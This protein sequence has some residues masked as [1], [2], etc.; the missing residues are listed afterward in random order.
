MNSYA[1]AERKLA[2]R[3]KI[4]AIVAAMSQDEMVVESDTKISTEQAID[5]RGYDRIVTKRFFYSV[6][7]G[8]KIEFRR[9]IFEHNEGLEGEIHEERLIHGCF[10]RRA[11]IP[12]KKFMNVAAESFANHWKPS[13]L[14]EKV[15]TEYFDG[16]Y[17]ETFRKGERIL[18]RRVV[19]Y[20]E[21]YESDT[22]DEVIEYHYDEEGNLIVS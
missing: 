10:K 4:V 13:H 11:I 9:I 3:G 7:D 22:P 18:K 1:I 6:R 20:A 16:G 15:Q 14:R 17:I 12:W 2:F 21:D 19:N 5:H 8:E